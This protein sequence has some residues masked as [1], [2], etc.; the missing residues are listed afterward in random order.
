MEANETYFIHVY[1]FICVYCYFCD[2]NFYFWAQGSRQDVIDPGG[3]SGQDLASGGFND[4]RNYDTRVSVPEAALS[5]C[6]LRS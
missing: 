4:R 6:A 1:C 3:D 2:Y 5:A